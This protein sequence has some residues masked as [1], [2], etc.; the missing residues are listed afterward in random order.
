MEFSL[1]KT[2]PQRQ[3]YNS[4]S[5]IREVK[6]KRQSS[7]ALVKMLSPTNLPF[8]NIEDMLGFNE[9]DLKTKSMDLLLRKY[10]VFL[11]QLYEIEKL[12][13]LDQELLE[14]VLEESELPMTPEL[15]DPVNSQELQKKD[16]SYPAIT[17]LKIITE[18]FKRFKNPAYREQ[19]KEAIN[20]KSSE[21]LES[22]NDAEDVWQVFKNMRYL[23]IEQLKIV[24][25][26][27][28]G[29]MQTVLNYENNSANSTQLNGTTL[30]SI[31]ENWEAFIFVHNH[32]RGSSNPSNTDVE[33]TQNILSLANQKGVR[34]ID[35]VVI[36]YDNYFSFRNSG[37][38][39]Q[40]LK[41]KRRKK[42]PKNKN[43]KDSLFKKTIKTFKKNMK[44]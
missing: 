34:I 7:F 17:G 22:V 25:F 3:A 10:L 5:R 12:D 2:I 20:S 19:V 33:F 40:N 14:D 29:K 32:P 39:M 28:F 37:E 11:K 13:K 38:I 4:K 42:Q 30:E 23:S 35:H 21:K 15:F 44:N 24:C 9:E 26:D 31:F 8:Q 27:E 18:L 6:L 41:S 1:N 16:V 36:G 43:N